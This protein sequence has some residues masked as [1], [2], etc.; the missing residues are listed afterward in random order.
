MAVI[1]YGVVK[2]TPE[3]VIKDDQWLVF[4]VNI[5]IG[6]F[7]QYF[8]FIVNLSD[9]YHEMCSFYNQEQTNLFKWKCR[10]I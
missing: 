10:G 7:S 6:I 5:I 8:R 4:I 2:L 1:N 9:K 3:V